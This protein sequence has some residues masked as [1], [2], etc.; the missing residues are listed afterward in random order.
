MKISTT[1]LILISFVLLSQ[2]SEGKNQP[3]AKVRTIVTTDG[4]VDD[5]DSFIR[6]LLY[7][8]EFKV[9]GLIYTSSMWHYKGDGKGTKFT[10]E[11]P[12]TAKMYGAITDLRWVG[13]TW[14]QEMID[15]YAKVYP[16]LIQHDPSYPTPEYLKSIIRVGNIDFEGEMAKDTE[17]S[18]F[19]KKILLD[20]NDQPVYVQMWGGT[21]TLAR[22][23]KSIEDQYK[24]KPEWSSVCKK[25][26]AKTILYIILDQDAAYKKYVG[27]SWPDVK[28]IYNSRQFWC[29]AYGGVRAFPEP[30]KKYLSG[31]WFSKNIISGHGPLLETYYLWGDGRQIAGDKEH[32]QGSEEVMKK[33]KM[34]KYDFLSEGDSPSYFHLL[35]FGLG[36]T[37]NPSYGGLGGRF[38]QSAEVKSRCEDGK[39]SADYNSFTQKQDATY[40]QVRWFGV[41]QNDFAAR[42]DW[43]VKKYSE[44][45]H[46]PKVSVE[47]N[48]ITAKAGGK[49]I[50]KG[51]ATDPDKNQLA[52]GWWQYAEAGTYPKTVDI[53]DKD[54]PVA[55]VSIPADA[56]KGQTL[57]F[58]LEVTDNGTPQ[59]T[60]FQ[61]IVVQIN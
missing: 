28:V 13:T 18:D 39:E 11:M 24:G 30:L 4:E 48:Q 56:V 45:N 31:E 20:N 44:A 10:S 47:T 53:Q 59:L 43:C 58:I 36:Q 9:E 7:T 15:K 35:N 21:N 27:K 6:M 41:L 33:A 32:N 49:I 2:L 51:S 52:Y 54:K 42:A 29:L 57:H 37:E 19:I 26:S 3:T 22:A 1:W 5:M 50:L 46:A 17:G 23:L 34:N 12:M 16:N 8:N 14:M 38:V 60:R 55:T 61:R 40:A 25:V